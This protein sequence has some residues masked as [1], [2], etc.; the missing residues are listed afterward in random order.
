[1]KQLIINGA[2]RLLPTHLQARYAEQWQA[3]L[4]GAAELGIK[5]WSI[6]W[7]ALITSISLYGNVEFTPLKRTHTV[8][9]R[10]Q[11][12]LG[13]WSGILVF[14]LVSYFFE[15]GYAASIQEFTGWP[16]ALDVL[17]QLERGL[18]VCLGS[19]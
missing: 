18:G 12:T 13:F 2:V 1:M 4:D 3:D 17:L 16:L 14:L 11:I 6:V 5:P 8:A 19:G 7:G 9:D 15:T 10:A